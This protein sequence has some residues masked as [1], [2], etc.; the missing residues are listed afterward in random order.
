VAA[1]AEEGAPNP[2]AGARAPMARL[3]PELSSPV[4][5]LF[6]VWLVMY[7]VVG[8]QMAWVLRP[9][10]GAPDQPF[11]LFRGKQSNFFEALWNQLVGIFRGGGW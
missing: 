4:K 7:A 3:V 5:R 9:F 8:A 10:I 2:P 6:R 1:L 11:V